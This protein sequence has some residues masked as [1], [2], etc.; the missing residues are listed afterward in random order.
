MNALLQHRGHNLMGAGRSIAVQNF[1]EQACTLILGALYSMVA[2]V[3]WSAFALTDK[4]GLSN[5]APEQ[6]SAY[7]AISLMGILVAWTMWLIKRWHS[8]N[9]KNHPEELDRLLQIA[10][11]DHLHG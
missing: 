1:N 11:D 10:R 9:L 2:T 5:F 4:L 6:L 7:L 8:A 3:N